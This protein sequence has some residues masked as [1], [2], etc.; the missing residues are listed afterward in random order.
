V[1]K[2]ITVR[3]L[4]NSDFTKIADFRGVYIGHGTGSFSAAASK[5]SGAILPNMTS[6]SVGGS[7]LLEDLQCPKAINVLA[8]GCALPLSNIKSILDNAYTLYLANNEVVVNINLSGGT[9]SAIDLAD[10]SEV[11]E[12]V[13]YG[14]ISSELTTNGTVTLNIA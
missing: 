13:E 1:P 6:V 7:D 5:L 11:H 9:N 12:G 2:N 10:S 3:R 14:T 8:S 4:N